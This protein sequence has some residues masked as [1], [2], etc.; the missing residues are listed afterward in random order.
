MTFSSVSVCDDD[1]GLYHHYPSLKKR[2]GREKES[3]CERNES[4]RRDREG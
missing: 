3:V 1:D 2:R 4:L